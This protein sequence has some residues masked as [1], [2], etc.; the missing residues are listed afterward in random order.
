M[1]K[2][3]RKIIAL[4]DGRD[5]AMKF[6]QYSGKMLL[7]LWLYDKKSH[8]VSAPRLAALV[9]TLSTTRKM[10]R[11]AH[12]VEP[13]SDLADFLTGK[14]VPP[15]SGRPIKDH[16][17]YRLAFFGAVVGV[18]NDLADDVYSLAKIGAL[19]KS[20]IKPADK[21]ANRLWLA[22]I[23]VDTV[24][25]ADDLISAEKSYRAF[26]RRAALQSDGVRDGCK[27][28]RPDDATLDYLELR[29]LK[30]RR[31]WLRITLLKF[32]MDGI[33]CRWDITPE[34][35]YR[36]AIRKFKAAV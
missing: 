5:K 8:P 32:I 28:D 26:M 27:P 10:I 25:T 12:V 7:W 11:L 2:V 14:A 30:D 15:A 29:K 4:T 19:S 18:L 3:V 24:S 17:M 36:T 13:A 22:G 31:Y 9:S 16:F 20:L 33:F 34:A 35:S 21:L 6:V 23:V 1:L